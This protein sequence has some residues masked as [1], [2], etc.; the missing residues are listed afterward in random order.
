[1][2]L[3]ELD[4][5]VAAQFEYERLRRR[6]LFGD[7]APV[8]EVWQFVGDAKAFADIA[9]ATGARVARSDGCEQLEYAGC[10][11]AHLRDAGKEAARWA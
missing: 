4:T 5:L 11:F 3:D 7:E 6:V 2:R 1:M 10:V 9:A 8:A